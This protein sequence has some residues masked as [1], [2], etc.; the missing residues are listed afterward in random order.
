[1]E[2]Q[3]ATFDTLL[4]HTPD[5]VY[6]LDSR[7]RFVYANRSLL[8]FWG[9]DAGSLTGANIFDLGL[10]AESANAFNQQW[11]YVVSSGKPAKHEAEFLDSGGRTICYEYILTPIAAPDGSVDWV[12]GI[13]RDITER[14]VAENEL[15]TSLDEKTA[16]LREVHHRVK[17]NLQIISS[18]LSMQASKLT[19]QYSVAQ[20]RDSEQR[21]MSMALI[22]E[23]LYAHDDMASIDLAT[24]I[25]NLASHVFS[26]QNYSGSI[27]CLFE[28][29]PAILT[30]EQAI[31][32][33]LIL[34]ELITNALKYAYPPGQAGDIVVGLT[35]DPD[36]V[37]I[38]VRDNGVGLP[39]TLD[40]SGTL[41]MRLVQLLSQ[42]LDG[43]CTFTN[44]HPGTTIT[45]R[46][47][48]A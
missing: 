35:T 31:P 37:A 20:L 15:K 8:K 39:E 24:Y 14:K 25:H 12:A 27:Q 46:F 17:N 43:E 28:L 30:V 34:N 41:G 13:S 5:H 47:P 18:L 45:I 36:S 6:Q 40:L 29:E 33:G 7:G 16:L 32:C 38:S 3:W 4:S 19:D 26:S 22:H 2:R 21:V 1:M 9:K 10:P 23:Q 11:Q 44:N 48:K 42:Q